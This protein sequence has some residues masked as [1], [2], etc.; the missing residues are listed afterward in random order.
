MNRIIHLFPS[1]LQTPS[2]IRNHNHHLIFHHI[3]KRNCGKLQ[4]ASASLFLY[5]VL[6]VP[7]IIHCRAFTPSSPGSTTNSDHPTAT[8]AATNI[9]DQGSNRNF[10]SSKSEVISHSSFCNLKESN[11]SNNMKSTEQLQSQWAGGRDVWKD[12]PTTFTTTSTSDKISIQTKVKEISN[13]DD[14]NN[15]DQETSLISNEWPDIVK[16][17]ILYGFGAYNPRGQTLPDET[18]KK[19]HALLR[20]DIVNGISTQYVQGSVTWWEGASIWEDGSSERGFIVAF[21]KDIMQMQE[22]N[23]QL[24]FVIALATKYNQGAIYRFEYDND[25][26][27]RDTIA[28]LDDGT[29]AK[30]QVLRDDNINMSLFSDEI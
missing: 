22:K 17:S 5:S 11:N 4:F 6:L 1:K 18:N 16:T 25:K 7:T 14:N 30:V 21:Q 24:D 20:D 27:M 8:T 15:N 19:Q 10:S 2:R 23:T 9:N 28:V 3:K 12:I 13:N 29:D 26:L